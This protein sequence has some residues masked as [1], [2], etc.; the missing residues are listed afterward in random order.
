[1]ESHLQRPRQSQTISNLAP[2]TTDN[3]IIPPTLHQLVQHS[4]LLLQHFAP[5]LPSSTT[6][7]SPTSHL[8]SVTYLHLVEYLVGIAP[9]PYPA[10]HQSRLRRTLSTAASDHLSRFVLLRP[11]KTSLVSPSSHEHFIPIPQP[12]DSTPLSCVEGC[13]SSWLP[14]N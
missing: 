3:P 9:A 10:P 5:T 6:T 7:L 13:T 4:P 14:H 1:M 8:I 11:L 2:Y 12:C